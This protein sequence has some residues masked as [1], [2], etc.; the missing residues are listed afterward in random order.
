ML[1]SKLKE[2]GIREVVEDSSGN[3][4]AAIAGYCARAE[5][6]CTI[7]CP[8]STSKGKLAQISAYGARLKLI[9]GNRAA[10]TE[11]VLE[12][13]ETSYYASHNWNPF[14]LEGTKTV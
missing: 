7:Y 3:A 12:A 13:A 2:L 8:A 14:F 11:A 6:G 10:T 9:E 1:I 5:I 4:G